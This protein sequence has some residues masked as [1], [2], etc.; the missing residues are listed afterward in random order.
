[1]Y[2]ERPFSRKHSI[3]NR[4]LPQADIA[5]VLHV[6]IECLLLYS[7]VAAPAEN[8]FPVSRVF[9]FAG[10]RVFSVQ[11]LEMRVTEAAVAVIVRPMVDFRPLPWLFVRVARVLC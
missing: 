5:V 8:P 9:F 1:M 3:T 11:V 7:L 6:T 2:L 4:A 10:M